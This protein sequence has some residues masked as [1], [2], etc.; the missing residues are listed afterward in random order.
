MSLCKQWRI[1]F[2]VTLFTFFF[3]SSRI[4]RNAIG[5]RG[6]TKENKMH[7]HT[8]ILFPRIHW[9]S[10]VLN[11][12]TLLIL[13][14]LPLISI[15]LML[16]NSLFGSLFLDFIIYYHQEIYSEVST[17]QYF[18]EKKTSFWPLL[19]SAHLRRFIF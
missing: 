12:I 17:F 15:L 4:W 6:H 19:Y 13:L 5:F 7:R 14:W 2:T 11:R 16:V 3:L 9:L 10:S 18:W 1:H 8:A